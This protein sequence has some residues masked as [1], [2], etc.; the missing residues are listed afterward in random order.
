MASHCSKDISRS[1]NIS[2]Y[3][4]SCPSLI[5]LLQPSLNPLHTMLPHLRECHLLTPSKKK[6]VVKKNKKNAQSTLKDTKLSQFFN[7]HYHS[8]NENDS[9]LDDKNGERVSSQKHWENP[10]GLRQNWVLV[11]LLCP[12]SAPN[13]IL[14]KNPNKTKHITNPFHMLG[15]FSLF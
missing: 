13:L 7:S 10:V 4:P 11:E 5:Q 3:V 1:C 9:W 12:T 2:L 15:G 6:K 14:A 8:Q